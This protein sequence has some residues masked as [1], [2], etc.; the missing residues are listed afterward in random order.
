MIWLF[1]VLDVP[2]KWRFSGISTDT[3]SFRS[4]SG[5]ILRTWG[6]GGGFNGVQCHEGPVADELQTFVWSGRRKER[7]SQG[8]DSP[9]WSFSLEK[10]QSKTKIAERLNFGE[11][12]LTERY[13]LRYFDAKNFKINCRAICHQTNPINL[14]QP[15][16]KIIKAHSYNKR[17]YIGVG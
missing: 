13:R 11:F 12:H 16:G 3:N 5:S 2:W 10:C 8:W 1:E 4:Q 14:W 17:A 6:W 7:N 15:W 9:S